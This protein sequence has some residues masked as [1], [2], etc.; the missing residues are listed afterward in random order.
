M[1]LITVTSTLTRPDGTPWAFATVTIGVVGTA[2]VQ[3]QTGVQAAHVTRAQSNAAGLVTVALQPLGTDSYYVWNPPKGEGPALPFR[4]P[5]SGGPYTLQSCL[6]GVPGSVITDVGAPVVPY[7]SPR[8]N[9]AAAAVIWT[10][11]SAGTPP[12]G[13]VSGDIWIHS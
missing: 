5:T 9:T 7:N 2:F 13:A 12:A 1:S 4:P 3:G 8:P 11:G 10:G 6:L